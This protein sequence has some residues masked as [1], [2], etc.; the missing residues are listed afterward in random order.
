MSLIGVIGSAARRRGVAPDFDPLTAGDLRWWI[1]AQ[2]TSTISSSG[3]NLMTI[4]DKSGNGFTGTASGTVPV[5]SAINGKQTIQ[6]A[7]NAILTLPNLTFAS[8][9]G[10]TCIHAVRI[11]SLTAT[12]PGITRASTNTNHFF[13]LQQTTGLPFI[14]WSSS[15]TNMLIPSSGTGASINTNYIMTWRVTPAGV[16]EWRINGA[17]IHSES[18]SLTSAGSTFTQWGRNISGQQ[19]ERHEGEVLW[20]QD[21][22]DIDTVIDAENWMAA[23]WGITF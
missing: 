18:H 2:D 14:R 19:A 5:T 8:G 7:S 11:T 1:D 23:R 15:A 16:A 9:T 10:T 6:F 13:I 22:L 3:G 12:N 17:A 4:S 21:G 20:Y